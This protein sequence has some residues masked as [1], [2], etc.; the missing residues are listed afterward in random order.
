MK[1]VIEI[2]NSMPLIDEDGDIDIYS[3]PDFVINWPETTEE[4]S[5]DGE[6]YSESLDLEN[7]GIIS[8]NEKQMVMACG[9]DWQDPQ[10]FTLVSEGDKLRVTDVKHSFDHGLTEKEIIK[11]LSK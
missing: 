5:I 10:T 3:F 4:D 6:M 8:L 9:G 11:I 2:L 7:W 1:T